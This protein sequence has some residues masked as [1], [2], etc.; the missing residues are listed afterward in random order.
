VVITVH[1]IKPAMRRR[2]GDLDI[3]SLETAKGNW[4]DSRMKTS[5]IAA[6]ASQQQA[7]TNP[8]D[9]QTKREPSSRFSY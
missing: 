2:G 3:N 9:A 5:S 4:E 1:C 7:P 6:Q 8:I